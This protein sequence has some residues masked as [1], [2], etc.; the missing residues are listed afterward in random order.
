MDT[1]QRIATLALMGCVCVQSER[2]THR[3]FVCAPGS[4]RHLVHDPHMFPGGWS[5]WTTSGNFDG[6]PSLPWDASLIASIPEK[7]F[8]QFIESINS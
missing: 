8:M 3:H 4:R 5:K 1:E 7:L 6:Y 2:F